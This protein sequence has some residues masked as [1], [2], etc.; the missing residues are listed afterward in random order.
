[1]I[2]MMGG[3]GTVND[4]VMNDA[5]E[6]AV[7]IIAEQLEQRL[8]PRSMAI[9]GL[10]AVAKASGHLILNVGSR[11]GVKVTDRLQVCQAGEPVRDPANGKVLRYDDTLIGEAVVTGVNEVSSEAVFKGTETVKTGDKAKSFPK[12]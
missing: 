10:V 7:K 9:D 1:M 11:A 4:P 12:P 2:G 6:Q 8:P 3:A 5:T